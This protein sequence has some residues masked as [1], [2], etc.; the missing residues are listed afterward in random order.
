MPARLD[1]GLCGSPLG[2]DTAAVQIFFE[3][4]NAPPKNRDSGPNL[5][6]DTI[7]WL[8]YL[9]CSRAMF[10]WPLRLLTRL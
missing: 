10:V 5:A 2:N 6:Y 7:V 3:Q 9:Y 4:P 1:S 8:T